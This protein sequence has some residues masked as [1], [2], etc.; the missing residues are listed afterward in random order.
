[1][2]SVLRSAALVLVAIAT[3]SCSPSTPQPAPVDG[4]LDTLDEVANA[5]CARAVRCTD[6]REHLYRDDVCRP[7]ALD[8]AYW[9]RIFERGERV[10]DADR[11]ATCLAGLRADTPCWYTSWDAHTPLQHS[12][13]GDTVPWECSTL[14]RPGRAI[15]ESCWA[16]VLDDESI[17]FFRSCEG[18]EC[19][20]G[21]GCGATCVAF[22]HEGSACSVLP[23]APGLHCDETSRVCTRGCAVS[24]DC[25]EWPDGALCVDGQC[26]ADADL[27]GLG[28]ACAQGV[29]AGPA[30]GPGAVCRADGVCG[31]LVQIGGTCEPSTS[32]CDGGAVCDPA[33]STCVLACGGVTCGADAPYCS[34]SGS[35]TNDPTQIR[36]P[37][38]DGWVTDEGCPQGLGCFGAADLVC[39]RFT[40]IGAPCDDTVICAPGSSC[41]AGS[42]VRRVVP[43]EPCATDAVCPTNFDCVAGECVYHAA[44]TGLSLGWACG[45]GTICSQGACVA[46][47]CA[48]LPAGSSCSMGS[49]CAAGCMGGVCRP[50]QV[51]GDGEPCDALGGPR[52]CADGLACVPENYP[53]ER[54]PAVDWICR[55]SCSAS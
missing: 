34:G 53:D 16:D 52:V 27:P 11:A 45:D 47:A 5:L 1:V 3:P 48:W 7:P 19:V 6:D 21:A 39:T 37:V 15:G 17:G 14:T 35:C 12:Y 26:V 31:A 40:S 49:E 28:H 42:C 55:R 8:R 10:L 13:D 44:P 24:L 22:G 32:A 54:L 41:R 20:A 29:G 30:C 36:C 50:P 23:C 4:W 9:R 18:G 51:G 25:D 38:F 33:T 2:R 43:W 46:G